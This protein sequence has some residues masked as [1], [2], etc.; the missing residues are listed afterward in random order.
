MAGLEVASPTSTEAAAALLRD[1]TGPLLFVGG[2]T[3]QGWAGRP[4]PPDLVVDTRRL[5][6]L[7]DHSPA[8]MTAAVQA[9]MPLAT[10]QR[11]MAEHGQWLALDPPSEHAGATIG[12]LL[13]SGESGPRRLRHG[14]LRDLVIGATVVLADGT[15]AHVG[16]HVIKNVA[17][18]DLTKLMYG[19]LGTLGL[20]TEVVVRLHPRPETAASVATTCTLDQATA[21]TLRLMASPLEPSAVVWISAADGA[22]GLTVRFDGRAGAVAAQVAT[23]RALVG[24]VGLAAEVEE[25][26]TDVRPEAAHPADGGSAT[27]LRTATRPSDLPGVAGALTAA[28]RRSGCHA[29]VVAQT[30][31]GIL[32]VRLDGP[33][34]GQASCITTWREVVLALDGTVL[35]QDRSPALD[36]HL[37]V[38]GPPPSA[39]HLLRNVKRSLD[40]AGRC[41]PGR[42]GSW[43]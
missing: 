30:G 34:E 15:V 26:P 42:F 24:D 18:Y 5:A 28:A 40:P 39:V 27:R 32:D 8:D 7:V 2:G 23:T 21:L 22:G 37:D 6:A 11:T 43:Y 9:G 19:S 14:S 12:G 29:V 20:V 4:E 25:P 35:V 3:K 41:A 36:E 13:A 38:L 31:V 33:L 10:F 17:G 16:G 1:S